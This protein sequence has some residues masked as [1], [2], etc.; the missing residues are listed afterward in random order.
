MR[1]P[2]RASKSTRWV[3]CTGSAE[4]NLTDGANEKPSALA[5]DGTHTHSLIERCHIFGV[6][7]ETYSLQRLEDKEGDFLVDQE[8][9]DRANVMLKV[10]KD[11]T[12]FGYKF[13][14][15]QKISVDFGVYEGEGSVVTGTADAVGVDAL[16]NYVIIDYKDGR[17]DVPVV[18]NMQLLIYA[19]GYYSN[20][21][22]DTVVT[23][24][25]VQPRSPEKIKSIVLTLD[26]IM[27]KQKVVQRA[28]FN[29][30]HNQDITLEVG[31][32]CKW[33]PSKGNCSEFAGKALEPMK[34]DTDNVLTDAITMTNEDPSDMSDKELVDFFKS[35]PLLSEFIKAAEKELFHRASVRDVEG[36]K[37]VKGR[38]FRKWVNNGEGVLKSLKNAHVPKASWYKST[39]V[40]PAQMEKLEWLSTKG[41]TKGETMRL[42]DSQKARILNNNL[43]LSDPQPILALEEDKREKISTDTSHL[44]EQTN[45]E[46]S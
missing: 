18:D 17:T 44:F 46:K 7:P 29:I 6:P 26:D 40:S 16:G 15:E 3:N 2:L 13:G 4:K 30:N 43:D 19:L 38:K 11:Y 24:I 34:T 1:I 12:D 36:V 27:E 37:L 35:S 14:V 39:I 45:G 41:A 42:S 23:L 33:C 25:I 5:I 22:R 9:I 32:W 20:F 10:I 31:D 28:V 21:T 8:R